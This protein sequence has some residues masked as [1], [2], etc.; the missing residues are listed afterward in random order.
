MDR[1]NNPEDISGNGAWVGRV[2]HTLYIDIKYDL[3][4][5]QA[6]AARDLLAEREWRPS[7][8]NGAE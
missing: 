3:C 5:T 4:M 7:L 1:N 8:E 6:W 2:K